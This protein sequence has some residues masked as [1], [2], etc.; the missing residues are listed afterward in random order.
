MYISDRIADCGKYT[1]IFKDRSVVHDMIQTF[2]KICLG[3]ICVYNKEFI[4]AVAVAVR[5][6][7]RFGKQLSGLADHDRSYRLSF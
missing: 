3:L 5:L 7:E 6:A 4:A 1:V 2:H